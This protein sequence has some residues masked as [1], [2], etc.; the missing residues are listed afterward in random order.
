MVLALIGSVAARSHRIASTGN[1]AGTT[2]SEQFTITNYYKQDVYDR[3]LNFV[4][5]VDDVLI[6]QQGKITALIIGVGGFLGI[7]HKDF[8]ESFGRVQMAK[9]N[10]KWYLVMDADKETLKRAP[11]LKYDPNA[12]TWVPQKVETT[13]R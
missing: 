5:T 6:D 9:K 2:P 12:T 8:S 11:R 3:S 7:G 1:A 13:L 4:G 10:D